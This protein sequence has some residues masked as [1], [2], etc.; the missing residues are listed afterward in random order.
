M[1]HITSS[2]TLVGLL[3]YVGRPLPLPRISVTTMIRFGMIRFGSQPK[4]LTFHIFASRQWF[5]Y[6]RLTSGSSGKKHTSPWYTPAILIVLVDLEGDHW[7]ITKDTSLPWTAA[8][9]RRLNAS[10]LRYLWWHRMRGRPRQGPWGF[11]RV[12][13]GKIQ[14]GTFR[15]RTPVCW[16]GSEI[17][18][19]KNHGNTF[20]SLNKKMDLWV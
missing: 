17:F 3:R 2:S 18:N 20:L 9:Q 6:D 12:S 10:D 13:W 15:F 14:K 19:M 16:E 1:M 11:R 7:I 8:N 4:P 5:T